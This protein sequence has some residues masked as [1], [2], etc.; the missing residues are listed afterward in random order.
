MGRMAILSAFNYNKVDSILQRS[1]TC[2]NMNVFLCELKIINWQIVFDHT[3]NKLSVKL[4]GLM[5]KHY[6]IS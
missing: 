6:F 1:F 3:G 5:N 4:D 2:V